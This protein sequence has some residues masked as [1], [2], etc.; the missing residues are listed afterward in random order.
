M[1]KVM[2]NAATIQ[3]CVIGTGIRG[4]AEYPT[5]WPKLSM[6]IAMLALSPE[7]AEIVRGGIDGVGSAPCGR[8]GR[9]TLIANTNCSMDPTEIIDGIRNAGIISGEAERAEI[10]GYRIHGAVRRRTEGVALERYQW[11]KYPDDR[12]EELIP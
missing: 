5:T 6:P 4:A 12:P 8:H 2:H 1:F 11:A 3:K 9:G 7:C 10:I